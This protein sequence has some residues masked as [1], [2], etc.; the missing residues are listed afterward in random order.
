MAQTKISIYLD[1]VLPEAYTA[2]S[3]DE[4]PVKNIDELCSLYET[5][6]GSFGQIEFLVYQDESKVAF[7]QGLNELFKAK[8]MD[9]TIDAK[10]LLENMSKFVPMIV[11]DGDIVSRGVYPDLTTMRGGENS[12]N[13]GGTG[14]HGD[15]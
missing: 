7:I 6:Y 8:D 2:P 4:A 12:I 9:I 13:R 10:L 11:V 5:K 1:G 14:A 3:N 15:H